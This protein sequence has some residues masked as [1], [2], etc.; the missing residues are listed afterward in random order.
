MEKSVTFVE[1]I[2]A[3]VSCDLQ[4]RSRPVPRTCLLCLHNAR[5]DSLQ[6]ARE[7]ERPLVQCGHRHDRLVPHDLGLI[8]VGWIFVYR[9]RSASPCLFNSF[10]RS[11]E[12]R[13]CELHI[14]WRHQI[15]SCHT[16]PR[17]QQVAKL[18]EA[19]YTEQKPQCGRLFRPQ[20]VMAGFMFSKSTLVL[21]SANIR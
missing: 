9:L 4:F 15:Q 1:V 16:G 8:L 6:V 14:D 11:V 7:V 21:T 19:K 18:A 17:R 3:A 13:N 2:F 12:S 20:E 10:W 5:Q